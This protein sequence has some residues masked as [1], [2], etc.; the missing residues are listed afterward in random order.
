[1]ATSFRLAAQN[2]GSGLLP[3]LGRR[4]S[5]SLDATVAYLPLDRSGTLDLGV[6]VAHARRSIAG[7]SQTTTAQIR[8]GDRSRRR[9]HQL[10]I[11]GRRGTYHRIRVR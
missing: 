1:M 3:A 6:A 2:F 7:P 4:R 5:G 8:G 11:G 10:T 9:S